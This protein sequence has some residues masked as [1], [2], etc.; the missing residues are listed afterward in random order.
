MAIH[1]SLVVRL[2]PGGHAPS[3][4]PKTHSAC[5]ADGGVKPWVSVSSVR[6]L[7]TGV[8]VMPSVSSPCNGMAFH[9]SVT[10]TVFVSRSCGS[11]VSVPVVDSYITSLVMVPPLTS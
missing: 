1:P 8:S 9:M 4:T 11:H 2:V 7:A 3:G 10:L 5:V 6:A